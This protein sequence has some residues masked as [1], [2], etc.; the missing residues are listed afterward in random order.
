MSDQPSGNDQMMQRLEERFAND[1]EA[2][3]VSKLN[4][5]LADPLKPEGESGH[6]RPRPVLLLLAV[7]SL[8]AIGTFMYFGYRTP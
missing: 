4:R 7:I 2:Q 5:W 1:R 6:F 3:I 8:V